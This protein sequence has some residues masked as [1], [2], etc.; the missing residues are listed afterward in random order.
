MQEGLNVPTPQ[1][2]T[3][4]EAPPDTETTEGEAPPVEPE[5]ETFDAP[6]SNDVGEQ[7]LT[8]ADTAEA[9][10]EAEPE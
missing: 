7:T 2:E 5:G 1:E 9:E 3:T 8:Q 6:T 10:T 4:P